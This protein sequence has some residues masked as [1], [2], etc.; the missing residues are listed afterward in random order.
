[1]LHTAV[2]IK[3]NLSLKMMHKMFEQCIL[4]SLSIIE[5]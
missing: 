3:E 1:M 2:V 5:M 4:N